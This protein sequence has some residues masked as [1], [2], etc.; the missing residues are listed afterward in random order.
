MEFVSGGPK[1]YAFKVN[2]GSIKSKI[3][4]RDC[5]FNSLQKLNFNTIKE[6]ILN[7]VFEGKTDNQIKYDHLQF[8]K[9]KYDKSITIEPVEKS[10]NFTYDKRKIII[11]NVNAS[12]IFNTIRKINNL[13]NNSYHTTL[14]ATPEEILNKKINKN[15]PE[16]PNKI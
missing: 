11:N 1:N 8:K 13:Y 12:N 7:S 2:D 14:K 15:I 3:K 9:N 6:F 16:K 10:Y 4:A 5:S